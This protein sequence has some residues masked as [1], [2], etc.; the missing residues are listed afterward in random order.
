MAPES[1]TNVV[2]V[3]TSEGEKQV[4]HLHEL[5][6]PS[7]KLPNYLAKVMGL[8][9]KIEK[10]Q[11]KLYLETL[12]KDTE[13]L[14]NGEKV[15]AEKHQIELTK[16][17]PL[18]IKWTKQNVPRTLTL[19]LDEPIE[20][21]NEIKKI[22]ERQIA[23]ENKMIA[24]EEKIIQHPVQQQNVSGTIQV[25]IDAIFEIEFKA[26][27]I[28]SSDQKEIK[29]DYE[30][31][32]KGLEDSVKVW[33]E[34][35]NISN[36]RNADEQEL[37]K[38][39]SAVFYKDFEA[40]AENRKMLAIAIKD[41]K[42]N[43]Y[44]SSVLLADVLTRMGKQVHVVKVPGHM[45]LT[46]DQYDFQ[47]SP[48]PEAMVYPK[49]DPSMY[50]QR[51]EVDVNKGLLLGACGWGASVF[52]ERGRFEEAIKAYDEALKL[53]PLDVAS[54]GMK[55]VMLDK[56][57]R[58]EEALKAFD[59][60]LKLNLGDGDAWYNKGHVL[61]KMGRHEEAEECFKKEKEVLG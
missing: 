35:N 2:N 28:P 19:I 60:A 40:A 36:I 25:P 47:T 57:G 13:I 50:S 20:T 38:Y 61:E 9:I 4:H 41:N 52:S 15:G 42:F 53:N 8:S 5:L 26:L 55:G 29:R 30:Q 21:T 58:H 46:G 18:E 48:D 39:L 34:A 6:R 32:V 56:L 3:T 22:I 27:Q 43:C 45:F 51:Y 44:S 33:L 17:K 37:F 12:S 31:Y 54:W 14:L 23:E 10:D 7:A 49:L 59:E 16:G 11:V 1:K 24:E